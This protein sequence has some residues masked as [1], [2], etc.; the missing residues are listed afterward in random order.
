MVKKVMRK[1]KIF[2]ILL[3][4]SFLGLSYPTQAESQASGFSLRFYGNG[5]NDIDRVKIKI[6]NPAVPADIGGGDFTIEFWM[7]A[8]S[9]ANTGSVNCS[10]DSG[11]ITGNII[12]DR[13]I[14]GPGDNGDYGISLHQGRVAFGV[15][16]GGAGN[17]ICGAT[18][19][20]NNTWRHI[21]VTRNAT[22]GQLRIYVDG[23]LDAQGSGPPGDVTYRNGRTTSWS[24]DPYLVI[25]A[26][27]HDYAPAYPSYTGFVDEL[28]LSNNIRYA[29]NFTRPS[30]QFTTDSNT[31]AL[32]HFDEGPAGA[33]SGT[34]FDASGAAGGP[35]HGACRYGG[36]P[37]GPVYSTDVPFTVDTTPPV[38]SN[39]DSQPLDTISG[40]TWT[41]NEP[42]NSLVEYGLGPGTLNLSVFKSSY[43]TAHDI[44]LTGLTPNTTYYFRVRSSDVAGNQ[45]AYSS[46]YSFTTVPSNVIRRV[47]LP[48]ILKK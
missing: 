8:Q 34:V 37:S 39:I 7:K 36:S 33:C 22:S 17:T 15:S 10:T 12:I 38:I 27:K 31:M 21:A 32:F 40:I 13:D 44:I 29:S 43:V 24:N 2:V 5:V 26:E 19:A 11:W 16:V 35:S 48:I 20:A 14:F 18:V 30:T 1:I 45:S 25:G 46:V 6:D 41:T 3:L 28:R 4:F 42:A 47:F 23:V 9:N